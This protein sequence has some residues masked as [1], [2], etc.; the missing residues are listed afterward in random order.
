MKKFIF[1]VLLFFVAFP[2]LHSRDVI[3]QDKS[4]Q[5]VFTKAMIDKKTSQVWFEIFNPSAEN[6]ILSSFRISGVKTP[7]IL[8]A[9]IRR[10]NGI[11]LKPG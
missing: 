5:L 11:E 8:P 3:A 10:N 1:L 4:K 2:V 6:I 7:N 9:D